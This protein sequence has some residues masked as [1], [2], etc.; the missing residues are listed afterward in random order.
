M[1]PGSFRD[2]LQRIAHAARQ[3]LYG[4]TTY[5]WAQSVRQERAE[6]ERLFALVSFGDL[7]G[8]PILPPYYTLRL[9]PYVVPAINRW[10][11][12]LLRERDWTDLADL[13]GGID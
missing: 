3:V 5:E 9:L 11:R 13:I 7:V 4:M 6:V 8:V 2:R 12:S 1:E 10:K